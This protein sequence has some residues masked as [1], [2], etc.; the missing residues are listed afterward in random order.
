MLELAEAVL[1]VTGSK[2]RL[3]R[4][5][6]PQDDPKQRCPDITKARRVLDWEPQVALRDGLRA[7]ADYYRKTEFAT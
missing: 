6:L 4:A 2:S 3:T 5:P 1:E 7:T